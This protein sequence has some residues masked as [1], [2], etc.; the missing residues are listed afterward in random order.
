[1]QGGD[2]SVPISSL[3]QLLQS[4]IGSGFTVSLV[5]NGVVIENQKVVTV[6]SNLVFTVNNAGVVRATLLNNIT[7]VNF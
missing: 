2:E 1:M 7:S 6:D 3:R 5:V 4:L